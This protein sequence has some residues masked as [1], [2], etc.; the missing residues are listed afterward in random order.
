MTSTLQPFEIDLDML[1]SVVI[2]CVSQERFFSEPV[3][4]VSDDVVGVKVFHD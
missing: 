3:L 1:W 4:C 2:S